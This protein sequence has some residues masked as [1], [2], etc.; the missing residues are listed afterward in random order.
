MGTLG[1]MGVFWTEGSRGG[2]TKKTNGIYGRW[3]L[4]GWWGSRG[5]EVYGR[6]LGSS[7]VIGLG[8]VDVRGGGSP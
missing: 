1:V 8:V 7:S 3:E 2:G 4:M 5:L 6:S